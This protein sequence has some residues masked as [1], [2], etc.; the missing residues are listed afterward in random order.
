MLNE[1]LESVKTAETEAAQR[2]ADAKAEAAGTVEA[3]KANARS[4]DKDIREKERAAEKER[5]EQML[6]ER[7]ARLSEAEESAKKTALVFW[8]AAKEK[9]ESVNQMLKDVLLS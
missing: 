3:A 8:Q 9:Q 5:Q 1:M 6:L 7:E 2:I 4:M